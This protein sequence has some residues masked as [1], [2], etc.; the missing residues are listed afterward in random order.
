MAWKRGDPDAA[1]ATLRAIEAASPGIASYFL[2]TI[3]AATGRDEEAVAA[4]RRY[5]RVNHSEFLYRSWALP[6]ALYLRA[7]SHERLGEREDATATIDR[8]LVMWRRADTD[9]PLLA[10]ATALRARLTAHPSR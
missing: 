4:L 9:L 7:R 8:L 3:C 6:K 10:R 2:G 5:E 1:L